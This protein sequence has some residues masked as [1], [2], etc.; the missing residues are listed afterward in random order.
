VIFV[1]TSVWIAALRDGSSREA[2]HLTRLLDDDE[3]ALPIS[4]KLEILAGAPRKDAPK[5]ERLLAA[6]PVF[7]P[8]DG[9]WRRIEGWIRAART[10]GERFGIVDLLIAALAAESGAAIWSLDSDFRR[11]SRLGLVVIHEPLRKV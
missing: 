9:T 7:T 6:L 11:L 4:V 2:R 1:D 5:L 10:R 8:G 3:A